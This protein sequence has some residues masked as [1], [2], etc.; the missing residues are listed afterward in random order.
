M[1]KVSAYIRKYWYMY[2]AALVCMILQVGLDMLSPQV[3][4]RLIDDVLGKRQAELLPKLLLMIFAIGAGRAVFGYLKEFIFDATSS[5]IGNAIRKTLFVHVQGLSAEYF[6]RTNTGELMS[7]LKDDVDK[8]WNATGYV[9]MLVMEVMI[10]TSMILFFMYRLN[11]KLFII[12]VIAMPLVAV[13]AIILENRLGKVYEEISEEN[14]ALNT[15]A[16]ENLAGIHTV[17][18]F[19]REPFE[20]KK[21]LSHNKRYYELNMMQSKVLIRYQPLFQLVSRLLPVLA[22]VYGGFLVI[23]GEIT[24][25]TLGAFS[26]YCTNIVWPM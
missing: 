21:F 3:T 9:G 12:P 7:R 25:G 2:A 22:V 13:A 5:K 23:H 20:I 17:K 19:A 6:D 18:A 15:V 11:R 16:Q 10:H 14:A 1:I 4:A 24:L 8:I 26:E